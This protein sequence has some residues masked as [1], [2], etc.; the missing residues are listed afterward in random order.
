MHCRSIRKSRSGCTARAAKR[1]D[2]LVAVEIEARTAGEPVVFIRSR[3][4][5]LGPH[6]NC[7]VGVDGEAA[8][9]GERGITQNAFHL[10]AGL[11]KVIILVVVDKR[12]HVPQGEPAANGEAWHDRG[13]NLNGP[14]G[15]RG[16]RCCGAGDG[17]AGVPR[18]GTRNQIEGQSGIEHPVARARVDKH[19]NVDETERVF[20]HLKLERIAR[21]DRCGRIAFNKREQL[22][23]H[24]DRVLLIRGE[25]V[26][27]ARFQR[28]IGCVS[29][30]PFAQAQEVFCERPPQFLLVGGIAAL[31][32]LIDEWLEK[33]DRLL[34]IVRPVGENTLI[35]LRLIR[36]HLPELR[37]DLRVLMIG[38]QI[39]QARLGRET[40]RGASL[41]LRA[42]AGLLSIAWLRLLC[43]RNL[44]LHRGLL[45]REQAHYRREEKCVHCVAKERRGCSSRP[46]RRPILFFRGFADTFHAVLRR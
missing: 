25:L 24:L 29:F 46:G 31:R 16:D 40:A 39:L 42:R 1:D 20:A 45:P 5:P 27:Q 4:L 36:R 3:N 12:R 10:V 30:A 21:F 43:S 26:F 32:H 44:R 28:L 33:L 19:R 37:L 34:E 6:K 8:D 14:A 18:G 35:E 22:E 11:R 9:R 7:V 13:M 15:Q 2:H 23:W 41:Q 17:Q 38:K